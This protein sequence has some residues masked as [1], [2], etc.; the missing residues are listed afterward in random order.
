MNDKRYI[1]LIVLVFSSLILGACAASAPKKITL[2]MTALSGE[3]NEGL[4][5]NLAEYAKIQPNVEVNLEIQA[6]ATAWQKS[7]PTTTFSGSEKPDLSWWWCSRSTSYK[8]MIAGDLLEPLDDLYER[9]GWLD[10]YPKG[11]IDYYLEPDGHRYG[12]NIDVVWT[13]FIYYNKAIFQEVGVDV[14]TTWDEFYAISEKIRA[15]GYEPLAM[16]Y[17]MSVRS[18]LPDALMMR[19][20]TQEEYNAFMINWSKDAPAETLQYKWTDP[21]GVRIFQT[22]KDMADRQVLAQG[23][24]GL[25]DY[26]QAKAL[27]TTGKAAMYQDGSWAGGSAA[28]PKEATFEW[29][30]FYYPPIQ[31]KAYGPVGSWLPNCFIVLKGGPNVEAA[32]DLVAFL[33]KPESQVR[34]AQASGLVPGRI[35]LPSDQVEKALNE[36]SAAHINDVKKLGAPA[37]YEMVATPKLL[38]TLKRAI[39]LMLTG[40][41]SPQEAAA[42]MQEETEKARTE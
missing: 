37:L 26:A 6:D 30:Y 34:W 28:L 7:A 4:K 5:A 32:K 31:E 38:D 20:W 3:V 27:F 33:L 21:N 41:I 11:T 12:A 22:I 23:F 16:V 39:D 42:M 15:A 8:D 10:A 35:D 24:A 14:P 2:S 29:G 19:S 13:P 25:T 9:E 1:A 17:E 18:H 40:G 36:T